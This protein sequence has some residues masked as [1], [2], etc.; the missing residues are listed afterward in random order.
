H[1]PGSPAAGTG[2]RERWLSSVTSQRNAPPFAV[3]RLWLQDEVDPSRPAFLG[4]T[5]YVLLD[6]ISVLERF[7]A[8][9]ERWRHTHSGSVVELHAYAL[10]TAHR[11]GARAMFE[12]EDVDRE[13][14]T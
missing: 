14:V 4:T 11:G 2:A 8:G 10:G 9:A 12:S 7:E 5:G 6:N 13:A 1:A 3:L